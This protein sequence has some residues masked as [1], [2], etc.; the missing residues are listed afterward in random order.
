[1]ATGWWIKQLQ[2]LVQTRM[3]HWKTATILFSIAWIGVAAFILSIFRAFGMSPWLDLVGWSL[4]LACFSAIVPTGI[5]CV[6]TN[7]AWRRVLGY[8]ALHA[9]IPVVAVECW[10]LSEEIS[11]RLEASD[12]LESGGDSYLEKQRRAPFRGFLMIYSDGEYDVAD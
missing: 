11:F 10:F 12:H 6:R 9:L 8:F 4:A 5:H 2:E 7:G 3:A 1:M